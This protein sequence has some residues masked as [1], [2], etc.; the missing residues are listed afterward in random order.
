MGQAKKARQNRNTEAVPGKR[1]DKRSITY[2]ELKS[3]KYELLELYWHNVGIQVPVDI[4]TRYVSL[5]ADGTLVISERY[6]W[7]GP[8][9]PTVDTKNSLRASLVHDALYQLMDMGLL[10]WSH[11]GRADCLLRDIAIEDGM[12]RIRAWTWYCGVR[13]AGKF[14]SQNNGEPGE[15]PVLTAP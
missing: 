6:A 15:D 5:L 11:Q 4:I 12:W 14:W 8:S 10:P 7:D 2:R 13:L 1:M 3:Y 9:G